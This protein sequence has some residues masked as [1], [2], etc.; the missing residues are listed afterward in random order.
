MNFF[1]KLYTLSKIIIYP[2]TFKYSLA[3][4]AFGKAKY[5]GMDRIPN[6]FKIPKEN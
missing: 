6:G 1:C 5:R 3:S 2:L 4:R